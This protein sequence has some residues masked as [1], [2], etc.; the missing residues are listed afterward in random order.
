MNPLLQLIQALLAA[1]QDTGGFPFHPI[2]SPLA[3]LFPSSAQS[4]FQSLFSPPGTSSALES[5]LLGL[6]RQRPQGLQPIE[7]P[8]DINVLQPPPPTFTAPGRFAGAGQPPPV[9]RPPQFTAVETPPII[10]TAQPVQT[11]PPHP[12]T[13]TRLGRQPDFY[14]DRLRG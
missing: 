3:E 1:R 8:P 2:S 10:T 12:Y 4:P 5:I 13:P 11:I 7:T 14:Y 9:G 6:Q